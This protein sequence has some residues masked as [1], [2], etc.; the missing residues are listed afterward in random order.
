MELEELKRKCREIMFAHLKSKGYPNLTRRAI[1]EEL[2][3]MW[4]QFEE[5]EL[6]TDIKANGWN[7]DLFVSRAM[8]AA[9]EAAIVEH[10]AEFTGMNIGRRK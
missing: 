1:I 6:L 7:F 10:M 4:R 2:P 9:Q 8:D 3:A 5:A